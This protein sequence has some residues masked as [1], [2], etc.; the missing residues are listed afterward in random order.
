[1]LDESLCGSIS[2][3]SILLFIYVFRDTTIAVKNNFY[4]LFTVSN[5]LCKIDIAKVRT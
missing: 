1:M 4:K 2:M 5:Q 3:I